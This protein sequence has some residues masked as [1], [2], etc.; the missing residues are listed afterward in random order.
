MMRPIL[1]CDFLFV[2]KLNLNEK[3]INYMNFLI[4]FDVLSI[5]L[6]FFEI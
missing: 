3:N 4:F 6:K 5:Y 2:L 1:E